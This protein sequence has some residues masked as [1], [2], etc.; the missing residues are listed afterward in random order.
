MTQRQ[1]LHREGAAAD[2][3]DDAAAAA[4]DDDDDDAAAADDDDSN[5]GG[6][7]G[8]IHTGTGSIVIALIQVQNTCRIVT[9]VCRSPQIAGAPSRD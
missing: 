7:S 6:N 8:C 4:D 9:I 1:R 2:D 5:G 3:D